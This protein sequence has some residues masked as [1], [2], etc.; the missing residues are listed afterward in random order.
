MK[1]EQRTVLVTGGSR[2]IGRAIVRRFAENG[3]AVAF[4]YANNDEAAK[5]TAAETGALAI[6]ADVSDPASVKRAMKEVAAA[7]GDVQ[8][9]V[10]NA[11]IAVSSLL[12]DV[13]DDE[14]RR[15]IDTNLS[16]AFYLS[17]EV[18]PAMIR[19]Q[20]GCIV[21]IG[22]MWGKVGASCEVA[23]SA[24]KAGLRGLTMALAKEVGPSHVRV[25]CLEPG[26]I[27]TDMNRMHDAETMAFLADETPLC[28]IGR[29]EEVADAVFF[30]A[31]SAASFITGQIL[32]VDGG[33][34]V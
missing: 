20:D 8:V 28:R 13:S 34:A 25:N 9:L 26:V 3:D 30:L 24:S 33:F 18:L 17:R 2:G 23:Y 29:P 31:S 7:L 14:W 11:G 1:K 21:N 15:V 22:S 16:S 5:I 32:G 4:F 10:N 27:D 6:R 19:A 12:T